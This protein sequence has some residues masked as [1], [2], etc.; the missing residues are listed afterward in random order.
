M[1]ERQ[2]LQPRARQQPLALALH[3][4][5]AGLAARRHAMRGEEDVAVGMQAD[6]SRLLLQRPGLVRI[7]RLQLAEARS[8]EH[9]SELQSRENLV[10]RLL[11][12]KKKKGNSIK[13]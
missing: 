12:E 1:R 13:G 2:R 8:E 7:H 4:P 6:G 9:T 3:G 10:C 11:L 5:E